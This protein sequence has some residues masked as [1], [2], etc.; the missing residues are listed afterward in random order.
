MAQQ[1]A[2]YKLHDHR[3]IKEVSIKYYEEYDSDNMRRIRVET[4]TKNF[5]PNSDTTRHNPTKSTKVE[6]L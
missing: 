5:F 1:I 2:P 3:I 6:Y 4:E